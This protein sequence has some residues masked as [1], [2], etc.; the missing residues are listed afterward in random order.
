MSNESPEFI[1][2]VVA[3]LEVEL[4]RLAAEKFTGNFTLEL[5]LNQG[6][7]TSGSYGHKRM[8]PR[9]PRT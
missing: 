9:P 6:G 2:Y 8:L 7:M 1:R 3:S 4:E 5:C